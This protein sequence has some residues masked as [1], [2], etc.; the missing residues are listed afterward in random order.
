[1]CST[2]PLRDKI[3]EFQLCNIN[4]LHINWVAL[5]VHIHEFFKPGYVCAVYGP[6]YL[7]K[8]CGCKKIIIIFF[9]TSRCFGAG[10]INACVLL[11]SPII[12]WVVGRDHLQTVALGKRNQLMNDSSLSVKIFLQSLKPC[13]FYM[14]LYFNFY[15]FVSLVSNLSWATDS[16]YSWLNFS[17]TKG[18]C[19]LIHNL[20][21]YIL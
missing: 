12:G 19:I 2:L 20:I 17:A 13:A 3:Q 14:I 5:Y 11:A 6:S 7:W 4:D 21:N 15:L 8:T 10:D 18:I 1:M 9:S 16:V